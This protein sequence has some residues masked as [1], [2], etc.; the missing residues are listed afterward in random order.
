MNDFRNQIDAIAESM[1]TI[2]RR[3][4]HGYWIPFAWATRALVERGYGVTESVRAVLVK[5]DE[6]ATASAVACV[7][8]V[9]YTIRNQE[10]PEK[11]LALR[12]GTAHMESSTKEDFE[13]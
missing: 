3:K 11:L 12:G 1:G 10:W 7:R 4:S 9:Y 2:A 13:V 5:A 8:V 6:E